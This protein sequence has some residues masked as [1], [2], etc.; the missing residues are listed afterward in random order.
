MKADKK[1]HECDV[2]HLDILGNNGTWLW[3]FGTFILF[4]SDEYPRK[5][6]SNMEVF[7]S[8][9]N[10]IDCSE[11]SDKEPEFSTN[12]ELYVGDYVV[13]VETDFS[14]ATHLVS[15]DDEIFSIIEDEIDT[16]SL[17]NSMDCI[18][19]ES[20]SRTENKPQIYKPVHKDNVGSDWF[21][22]LEY[23]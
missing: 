17:D 20:E 5:K 7:S 11:I 3:D 18:L 10:N 23:N 8:V 1:T 19:L 14:C 2:Y 6:G 9:V 21:P 13:Y 16:S 22:V 12:I 4:G 15:P